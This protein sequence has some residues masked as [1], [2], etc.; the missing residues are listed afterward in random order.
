MLMM[1]LIANKQIDDKRYYRIEERRLPGKE[2]QRYIVP[3][4]DLDD[5]YRAD[6]NPLVQLLKDF[7]DHI[8]GFRIVKHV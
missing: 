1:Q 3:E 2:K 6:R 4:K 7:K 5:L 8:L